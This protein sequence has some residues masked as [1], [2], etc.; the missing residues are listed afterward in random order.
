MH[1][2]DNTKT[3]VTDGKA[4][5]AIARE[6]GVNTYRRLKPEEKVDFTPA[7]K[8]WE[9]ESVFWNQ[10][11]DAWID[12]QKSRPL[13]KISSDKNRDL[14]KSVNSLKNSPAQNG[15]WPLTE[16]I[17]GFLASESS[18]SQPH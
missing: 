12:L 14:Q 10:V 11:A 18:P 2:Q 1:E 13:L 5:G 3:I 4:T 6:L 7:R 17:S 8:M 16:T 9:K 15:R